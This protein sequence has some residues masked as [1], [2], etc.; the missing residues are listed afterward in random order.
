MSS[1]RHSAGFAWVEAPEQTLIPALIEYGERVIIGTYAVAQYIAQK[2]VDYARANARWTDRTGNARAALHAIAVLGET[3]ETERYEG[4]VPPEA[5]HMVEVARNLVVVFL[6]HGM[7]YGKYLETISAGAYA[8]V[9]EALQAH[10]GELMGLLED[11][12]K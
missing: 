8:I 2:V 3:G 1:G 11:L 4:D 9:M 5:E 12:F 6:S 10:Y 7:N